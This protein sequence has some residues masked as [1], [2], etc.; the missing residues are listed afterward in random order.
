MVRQF[1][2]PVAV[3]ARWLADLLTA[4][5]DSQ[6]LL[7]QLG[8]K[9]ADGSKLEDLSERIERLRKE[10]D[11]LHRSAFIAGKAIESQLLS[12]LDWL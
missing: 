9:H 2:S 4:L 7:A 12:D 11:K 3:R 5:D 8:T 1:E 6:Q 10:L